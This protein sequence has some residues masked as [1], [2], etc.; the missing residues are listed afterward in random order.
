MGAS[1]VACAILAA[2]SPAQAANPAD[3]S[4]AGPNHAWRFGATIGM[5]APV[6]LFDS[7]PALSTGPAVGVT[8]GH[9]WSLFYLGARYEHAFL[10][11]GSW[12]APSSEVYIENTTWAASDYAGIDAMLVTDPAYPIGVGVRVGFGG[13]WLTYTA[14]ANEGGTPTALGTQSTLGWDA[15][16]GLGFPFRV[17]PLEPRARGVAGD[18]DGAPSRPGGAGCCLGARAAVTP[19]HLRRLL[20]G[21]AA[22]AWPVPAAGAGAA[23]VVF[24]RGSCS[25]GGGSEARVWSIKLATVG[26]RREA[27][28]AWT[29][30][31]AIPL[32]SRSQ[33]KRASAEATVSSSVLADAMSP[34]RPAR[35]PLWK[36]LQRSAGPR[37][38][39]DS[40]TNRQAERRRVAS[41][42]RKVWTLRRAI[43]AKWS[44]SGANC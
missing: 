30:C 9:R 10:G 2:A 27:S 15:T 4:G 6:N 16:L 25:A 17:G 44:A 39:G 42:A 18:R 40:R 19:P 36:R 23:S 13:R 33:S 26:P 35:T 22:V 1:A 24:N 5:L 7:N 8:A 21:E 11:G 32:R 12:E 41:S 38:I 20:V 14:N 28:S 43:S 31:C 34:A 29:S 3:G 37:S